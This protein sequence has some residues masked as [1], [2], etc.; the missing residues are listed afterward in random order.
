MSLG[1]KHHTPYPGTSIPAESY[2][3]IHDI[4][5]GSLSIAV[6]SDHT[7][8]AHDALGIVAGDASTL[9]TH[10]S[11]YFA[12]ADHTHTAGDS[13]TLDGIDST[14]FALASRG[15]PTGS[16]F[17][18]AGAVAPTNYLLCDGQSYDKIGDYA[19]LFSVIGVVYGEPDVDHFKVP[20]L[21]SKFPLG[22]GGALVLGGV[23]GASS[24]SHSGGAVDAHAGSAVENHADHTHEFTEIVQHTHTV[25]ITDNG[26][27]HVITELRD[28]TS[29]SVTTNIALT[30]DTSSTIGSK[31]TGSRT[32][33]ITAASVNPS[34]SVASGT[35]A[36]SNSTLT[37]NVT[38][39]NN[40]AFTQPNEHT[41]VQP[42]YLVINYII[43]I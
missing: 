43:K 28:S 18:F 32:T 9:E 4:D 27:T 2:N 13:S 35:T 5:E 8:E 25:N 7:K 15:V 6:L 17:Q 24:F 38:Q 33:G 23:G 36:G 1:I 39:P 26:H 40:H 22:K 42:P 37:H 30:A 29:G 11:N 10:A 31:V 21:Q 12:T 19:S 14:G 41:G 16:I 20:D 3:E 34:G